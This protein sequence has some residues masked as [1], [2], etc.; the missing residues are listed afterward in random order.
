MKN[1]DIY[2]KIIE[3]L[4]NP[5]DVLKRL[6]QFDNFLYEKMS[7]ASVKYGNGT[8]P[9]HRVTRYHDFF[10]ENVEPHESVLDLGSGRGDVTFDV[11]KK[12][13]GTVMGV[14][15]NP[16]N[17]NH[18]KSTYSKENL[19]FVRG[20]ICKDI[21]TKHF[22]VVIMSN[23]LEHLKN[24]ADLLK[25]IIAKTTPSKVLLRVPHFER[26]WTVP[27]KKELGVSYFLDSTHEIE[28]THQEFSEEMNKAGLQISKIQVNWGEIWA[29]LV[30]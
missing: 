2:D 3:G 12:T 13:S 22:D 24:R 6:L 11:A 20:D 4:S 19:F 5:S 26:E 15:I 7:L 17:L 14:E 18:A 10:V 1:N 30:V 28:Y 29:L 21:C 25:N 8:H 27:I 23:V 16:H 9:K